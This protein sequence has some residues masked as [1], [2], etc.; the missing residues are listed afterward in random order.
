MAAAEA[1][2]MLKRCNN[3]PA[4]LTAEHGERLTLIKSDIVKRLD[5]LKIE[6]LVEK[7][8][9]LADKNKKEFIDRILKII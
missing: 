2:H 8:K 4:S 9:E 1:N 7:F 5:E 3:P 6:W